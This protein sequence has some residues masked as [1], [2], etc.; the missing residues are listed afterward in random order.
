MG[1]AA[2]YPVTRGIIDRAATSLELVQQ[3]RVLLEALRVSRLTRAFCPLVNLRLVPFIELAAMDGS[4][5]GSICSSSQQR[6]NSYRVCHGGPMPPHIGPLNRALQGRSKRTK[7]RSSASM[8]HP[9]PRGVIPRTAT[10][11]AAL[12]HSL[13]KGDEATEAFTYCLRRPFDGQSF[14]SLYMDLP[15]TSTRSER[16][17]NISDYSFGCLPCGSLARVGAR[18]HVAT[19]HTT[20]AW[21]IRCR[22]SWHVMPKMTKTTKQAMHSKLLHPLPGRAT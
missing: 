7:T 15:P 8:L 2:R 4:W 19:G 21:W 12:R 11:N 10:G 6:K 9:A 1:A 22:R 17:K 3:T 20:I 14:L 5:S 18:T 13:T 16:N